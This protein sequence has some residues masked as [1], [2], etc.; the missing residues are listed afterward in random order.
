MVSAPIVEFVPEISDKPVIPE[1]VDGKNIADFIDPDIMQRL[2]E[3]EREEE[4]REAAGQ[5]ESEPEDEETIHTRHLAE[6]IRKK[7]HFLQVRNR[8]EAHK[9][10]ILLCLAQTHEPVDRWS[11]ITMKPWKWTQT[12]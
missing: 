12:V 3:L 2:E 10:T 11:G 6:K 1:I 4:M 5:Y 9:K 7:R 8:G